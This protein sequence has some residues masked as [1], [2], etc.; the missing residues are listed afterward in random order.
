MFGT[1]EEF[2]YSE[3]GE[4]GCVQISKYPDGIDRHYPPG[5]Y[6]FNSSDENQERLSG[7]FARSKRRVKYAVLAWLPSARRCYLSSAS[8]RRWLESYPS[9][10]VY[11]ERIKCPTARILDV[12]CGSGDLLRKLSDFYY[13]NVSGVDPFIAADLYYQGRL[14]VR[15]G[16]LRDLSGRFDCISFHHSLE[17]MPQQLQV[18]T[19]AR[20]LLSVDGFL[21]IRV[22]VVG[23][24]AWRK[25]R[26]NWVQLDAP[27]HLYL[28]SKKSIELLASQAGLEVESLSCDS[29]GFQFW[30]SELYCRGIPLMDPR[31]PFTPGGS[32]FS[33]QHF[34]GYNSDAVDLNEVGD[35]DQVLAILRHKAGNNVRS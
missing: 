22:P 9:V 4:C 15:R 23:G 24:E 8:T 19:D 13:R 3:C 21:L 17:H 25:Y 14:L 10:S 7:T 2:T 34:A 28:H 16:S 6:A 20:Q 12:G 32:I 26:E 29:T 33:A 18:L 1:R 31:S 5:Y 35:G 11:V 30:G 27:R